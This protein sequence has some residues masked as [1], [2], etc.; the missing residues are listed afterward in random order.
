MSLAL[1]VATW[2]TLTVAR[3]VVLTVYKY[4]AVRS[5]FPGVVE[6]VG[7]AKTA[8][9]GVGVASSGAPEKIRHNLQMS[10]AEVDDN[11]GF[12]LCSRTGNGSVAQLM[13]DAAYDPG[14]DAW[15]ASIAVDT[16]EVCS[17][18]KAANTS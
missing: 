17:A 9:L 14:R 10:G 4:S 3:W 15:D 13:C 18:Q 5:A 12:S 2:I 6:L 1:T 11:Y 8:G 16:A 7:L